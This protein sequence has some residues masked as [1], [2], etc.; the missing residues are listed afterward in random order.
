R[1]GTAAPLA[2]LRTGEVQSARER[3]HAL[4]DELEPVAARLGCAAELGAAR[5]LVDDSGA[6]RQRAVAAE[7]GLYGL[8]EWLAERFLARSPAPG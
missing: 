1:H 3:L 8:T 7:R 4:L 6:A 5:A 2:D